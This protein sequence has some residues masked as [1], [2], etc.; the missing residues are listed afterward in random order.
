MPSFDCNSGG[1]CSESSTAGSLGF[2]T[3]RVMRR[4]SSICMMPSDCASLPPDGNGG[5]GD[6]RAGLDVLGDDLAEIHP[7]QL[8]AAQDEEVIEI[9]VE[10]MHQI[11]AHGVGRALIPRRVGKVCCAARIS[12]KPPV[13]WSNLYDREMCRCSEAELN[14]VSI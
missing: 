7:I 12:T 1:S 9:V 3:K 4:S 6:V 5:D 11:F 2:S 14:C 10:E 8:V 13:K